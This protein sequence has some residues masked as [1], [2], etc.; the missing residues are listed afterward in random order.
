MEQIAERYISMWEE[1]KNYPIKPSTN[2]SSYLQI[3]TCKISREL[4]Q[5]IEEYVMKE[6]MKLTTN[7]Y[8]SHLSLIEYCLQ[9]R[10]EKN[11]R[12]CLI[13]LNTLYE[14]WY[15]QQ[16]NR[17]LRR[18]TK[19]GEHL[20]PNCTQENCICNLSD[21]IVVKALQLTI[22]NAFYLI[23]TLSKLYKF[24]EYIDVVRPF[25]LEFLNT[26]QN[27]SEKFKLIS[28]IGHEEFYEIAKINY[29]DVRN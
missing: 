2:N 29:Q 9:K 17:I 27:D 23:P 4:A 14:N 26:K 12:Q 19:N 22:K 18:T 10:I 6:F 13:Y 21:E 3:D 28:E 20:S 5:K 8:E 25:V 11:H 7:I 15:K 16:K 1:A 24:C